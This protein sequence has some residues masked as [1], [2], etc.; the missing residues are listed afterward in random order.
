MVHDT[1]C[2]GTAD[3][4]ILAPTLT[5]PVATQATR[6]KNILPERL[7]TFQADFFEVLEGIFS[8]RRWR[9]GPPR[10][11]C[12][13]PRLIGGTERLVGSGRKPLRGR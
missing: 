13:I 2:A 3:K 6:L 7:A 9:D 12:E 8:S 1:A 11:T 5:S 4:T 10:E